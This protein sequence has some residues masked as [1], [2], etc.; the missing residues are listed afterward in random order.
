MRS[1]VGRWI[2]WILGIL[3]SLAGAWISYGL[4]LEHFDAKVKRFQQTVD[5]ARVAATQPTTQPDTEDQAEAAPPSPTSGSPDNA[6]H[7]EQEK[8][9]L[10]QVCEAFETS[11]CEEVALSKWGEIKLGSQAEASAIPTA[12]LGMFYFLAVAWWLVLIGQVSPSRWWAHL[13]LVLVAAIGLAISIFLDVIMFSQLEFWCPW[14]LVTHILSLLLFVCVLLLWPRKLPEAPTAPESSS[15]IHVSELVNEWPHWWMLSVTPVVILLTLALA[16]LYLWRGYENRMVE[17]R[18]KMDQETIRRA[19]KSLER[20]EADLARNKKGYQNLKQRYEGSWQHMFTAW[21]IAPRVDIP[22]ENRPSFGPPDARHTVVIFS[23]FACPAC[24]RYEKWFYDT[25]VPLGDR[26]GGLKVVFKHWPICTDGCNPRVFYNLH[27]QACASARAAE[28]AFV[29]GG[30]DAFWKMHGLLFE[31]DTDW[32]PNPAKFMEYAQQIGLDMNAF[33][34]AMDSEEVLERIKRDAE[35]GFNLGRDQANATERKYIQV[36]STPSLFVDGKRLPNP[37]FVNT[38]KAI[39]RMPAPKP[40]P[41]ASDPASL[42]ED[43]AMATQPSES[44]QL[45]EP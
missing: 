6:Q 31:H 37:G 44:E 38:W 10:E 36:N 19:A 11:S 15:A 45:G 35:E 13:P 43:E 4:T 8:G 22:I 29:V 30:D 40:T 1:P 20:Y 33:V 42:S 24:R 12:L 34:A 9:F 16:H 3:L 32:L 2:V 23:D 21:Q 39:L 5:E 17:I 25:I 41:S 28:A 27:P 18:I 7:A 14:C 26:Y